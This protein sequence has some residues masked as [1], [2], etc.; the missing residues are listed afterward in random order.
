MAAQA[1]GRDPGS[2][3]EHTPLPPPPGVAAA[4]AKNPTP[5]PSEVAGTASAATRIAEFVP[6]PRRAAVGLEAPARPAEP[7]SDRPGGP[8]VAPWGGAS[9]ATP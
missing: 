5:P 8:R 3:H 6:C 9:A 4:S 1:H 2:K 7:A